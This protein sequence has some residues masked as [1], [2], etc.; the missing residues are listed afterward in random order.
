MSVD[1]FLSRHAWAVVFVLLF[2][3]AVVLP[4]AVYWW[5][6]DNAPPIQQLGYS[7][8]NA[9]GVASSVFRPGETFLIGRN[10][11]IDRAQS[12]EID[13]RLVSVDG[14]VAYILLSSTSVFE[15]GCATGSRAHVVPL[16]AMPGK[17]NF[18]VL[19]HYHNNPLRSGVQQLAQPLLEIEL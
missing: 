12:V 10:Y 11:C 17:Y 14:K 2:P 8:T 1:F 18:V 3:P 13:R 7:I 9:A 4:T 5:F 16:H 19:I 15:S 6:F